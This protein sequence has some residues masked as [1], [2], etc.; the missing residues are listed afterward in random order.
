MIEIQSDFTIEGGFLHGA[1]KDVMESTK[2]LDDA[3][4]TV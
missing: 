1:A 3:Q 2:M 4:D